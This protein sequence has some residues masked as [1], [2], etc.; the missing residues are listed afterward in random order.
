MADYD[1]DKQIEY[2]LKI[3]V[4]GDRFSGKTSIIQRYVND[5]FEDEYKATIGVDFA[6]KLIQISPQKL[7]RLQ[8]WDI[9]GQ[10]R[11]SDLTKIYYREALGALIVFDLTNEVSFNSVKLWKLGIDLNVHLPDANETPIPVIL[12]ANKCDLIQNAIESQQL[13]SFC[14]E[15][16]IMAWFQTSAKDN[17]NLEESVTYLVKCILATESTSN[18]DQEGSDENTINIKESKSIGPCSC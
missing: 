16:G 10:Q 1:N 13:D 4:V 6:Y 5:T 17:I 12:L 18:I 14:R 3:L 11:Y 8:L 7:V 15:N 9:A 2:L